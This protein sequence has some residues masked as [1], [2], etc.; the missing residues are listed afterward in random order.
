MKL[1]EA[2]LIRK[3]LQG[4]LEELHQRILRNCLVQEGESPAEDPMQLLTEHE[5]ACNDLVAL[6]GKINEANLRNGVGDYANVA[7][8]LFKK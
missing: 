8:A 5:D 3:N 4:R 6:V 1:A 7:D 2:L